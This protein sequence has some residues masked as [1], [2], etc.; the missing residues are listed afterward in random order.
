MSDQISI[1]MSSLDS[2][3]AGPCRAATPG[4]VRRDAFCK[5]AD[6][7]DADTPVTATYDF[8]RARRR[9][10]LRSVVAQLRG[11]DARL[12]SYEEVRRRLKAVESSERR[13]EDVP[14][15]AIVGSVGRYQ[16]FTREF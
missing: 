4:D 16:D 6:M 9:A 8:N 5:H 14:L 11:Q 12:L 1:F 7:S 2:S 13:L 10:G 3:T 15:D